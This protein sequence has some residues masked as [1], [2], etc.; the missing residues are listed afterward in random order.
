GRRRVERLQEALRTQ[1]RE[2]VH[3][4]E[5][6]KEP[7]FLQESVPDLL[8]R[9]QDVI[10]D[11]VQTEAARE[12]LEAERGEKTRRLKAEREHED[13]AMRQLDDWTPA[14]RE[15]VEPLGLAD[16][17]GL[18]EAEAVVD[19]L[20]NLGSV[21]RE[22]DGLKHRID[23]IEEDGTAFACQVAA[24]CRQVAPEQVAR[25]VEEAA[26]E[27]NGRLARAREAK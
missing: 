9:C 10:D 13:E 15:Q 1:R 26:R 24:L 23:R 6:L 2:L 27:V 22:A 17:A 20:T 4:L 8:D 18:A 16:D 19:A 14:W 12:T 3:A 7:A 25:P 5:R 11:V 21:L